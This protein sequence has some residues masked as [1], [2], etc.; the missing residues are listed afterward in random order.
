MTRL[1]GMLI[2]LAMLLPGIAWGIKLAWIEHPEAT[3]R[4]LWVNHW[5]QMLAITVL[6]LLG[7]VLCYV[8][9]KN[10]QA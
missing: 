2:G 4:L 3:R 8:S 10:H 9:A 5:D 1:L 7:Y 6:S